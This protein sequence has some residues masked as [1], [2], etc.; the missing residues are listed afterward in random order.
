M[1][2]LLP[3][4]FAG[5]CLSAAA[6]P[7]PAQ[8]ISAGATSTNNAVTH[9]RLHLPLPAKPEQFVVR[10]TADAV[11]RLFINGEPV[12]SGPTSGDPKKWRYDR[13]DLAP[14]LRSGDNLLAAVV[15]YPAN[16]NGPLCMMRTAPGFFMQG[17][18]HPGVNT[19]SADWKALGNPAYE[20]QTNKTAKGYF[21]LGDFEQID[22]RIYPWG[23]ET[24]AFDDSNWLKPS[25]SQRASHL[26]P[27]EIPMMERRQDRLVK[28]RKSEGATVPDAFLAGRNPVVIPPHTQAIVLLD[29]GE[30]VNAYPELVLSGGKDA[31]VE[32]GYAEA[33]FGDDN[34]KGDRSAIENK[35]WAGLFDRIIAD[36]GSHRCYRPLWFRTYRYVQLEIRTAEAPLTLV[37][38]YGEF[39]GYPFEERA[40]FA[41]GDAELKRIWDVGWRTVRLCAVENFYDCP[42]YERL[43]YVGDTRIEALVSVYVSGDDRLMRK[44][45]DLFNDSLGDEGLTASRYPSHEQ[46]Q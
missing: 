20:P 31:I 39:T 6:A 2:T 11:Y 23:W 13:I 34:R 16:W 46:H 43:Q 5:L 37:D 24:A 3:C 32:M 10:V 8:W 41:A 26:V 25:P 29:R 30:L 22:G 45:I 9:Y 33:L 1:N 36:G 4:L 35:N 7:E 15:W 14:H 12:A 17:E 38:L 19:G 27:R 42:Y 44:A 21:A 28:V 18:T 40:S